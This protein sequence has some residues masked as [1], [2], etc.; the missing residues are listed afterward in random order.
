MGEPESVWKERIDLL[1]P[2]Q[3]NSEVMEMTGKPDAKLLHCL[4]VF[5]NRDTE[6]GEKIYQKL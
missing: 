4:P 1:R 3:V 6:I 5:H 2:Y